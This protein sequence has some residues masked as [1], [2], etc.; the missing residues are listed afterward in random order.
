MANLN[1]P[2]DLK[3]STSDE[4]VRVEGDEAVIGIS[5]YAQDQLGDIV[6]IELP[7]D[8]GQDVAHETKFGD[9]ESVKATSELISP[10]SG[11]I[12]SVN[13][14]LRDHPEFI[15]DYPYEKGWM[16]RVKIANPVEIDALLDAD[17]YL[18]YLQGR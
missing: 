14:E 3:Y 13:Q 12:V 6:Y 16:L 18:K 15:N 17:A 5:D 4:W 10:V 11:S 9:I 7:W 8:G 2:K 1:H